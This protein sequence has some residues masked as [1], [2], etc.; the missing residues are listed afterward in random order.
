MTLASKRPRTQPT[1]YARPLDTVDLDD[2]WP[3]HELDTGDQA[4]QEDDWP[5]REAEESEAV[6]LTTLRTYHDHLTDGGH[7]WR[8]QVAHLSARDHK[9]AQQWCT[10]EWEE[11]GFHLDDK[12][13]RTFIWSYGVLY[14]MV[15][16]EKGVAR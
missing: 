6:S 11:R 5:P 10:D 7:L 4:D 3:P 2:A 8:W 16:R 9:R 1:A 14:Q 15:P 13:D 12:D